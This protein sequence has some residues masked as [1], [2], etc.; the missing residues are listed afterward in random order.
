MEVTG[1]NK[2]RFLQ[3]KT[4]VDAQNGILKENLGIVNSVGLT[5]N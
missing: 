3:R 5:R 4:S 2:V 1:L